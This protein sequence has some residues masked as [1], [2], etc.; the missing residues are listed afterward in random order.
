MLT[1]LLAVIVAIA[2]PSAHASPVPMPPQPPT[3]V[4]DTGIP[5][6]VEL[7]GGAYYCPA[8]APQYGC[9][10]ANVIHLGPGTDR[11]GR[12]HEFCHA[13]DRQILTPSDRSLLA[14][15]LHAPSG[16]WFRPYGASEWFADYC[17]AVATNYDP[18]PHRVGGHMSGVGRVSY[19]QL[20]WQ[21]IQYT[22]IVLGAIALR[23][24]LALTVIR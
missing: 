4:H 5:T 16:D 1:A 9:P 11:F 12:A 24:R 3:V 7:G 17:A 10:Q 18:R 23:D 2:A 14:R 13:I 20:G 22:R 15:L 6:G 8:V 19:A 21:R